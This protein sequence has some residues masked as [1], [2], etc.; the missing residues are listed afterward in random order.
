MATKLSN[1]KLFSVKPDIGKWK[2]GFKKSRKKQV[3]IY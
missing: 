2:Q 3:T 1:N